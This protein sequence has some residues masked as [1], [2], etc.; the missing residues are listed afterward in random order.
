MGRHHRQLRGLCHDRG[1]GSHAA[2]EQ[3]SRADAFEFLVDHG[4]NDDLAVA[5][6]QMA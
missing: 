1:V 4:G 6:V 5:S 2:L 3:D